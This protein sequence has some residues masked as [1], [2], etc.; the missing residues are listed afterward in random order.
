MMFQTSELRV[1]NNSFKSNHVGC[2]NVLNDPKDVIEMKANILE[3]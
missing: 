3:K 2:P 1:Q